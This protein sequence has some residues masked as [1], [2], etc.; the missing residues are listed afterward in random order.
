LTTDIIQDLTSILEEMSPRCQE[1]IERAIQEIEER[2]AEIAKLKTDLTKNNVVIEEQDQRFVSFFK[3]CVEALNDAT[4]ALEVVCPGRESR[5][6]ITETKE[7]VETAA[8]EG[9]PF[10]V[11]GRI[12]IAIGMMKETPP[13]SAVEPVEEKFTYS[14]KTRV[15]NRAIAIADF[16]KRT[17]KNSIKS[18]EAKIVLE[19]IE[20]QELD[21]TIIKRAMDKASKLLRAPKDI[22]GGVARIVLPAPLTVPTTSP[23]SSEEPGGVSLS[24]RRGTRLPWG[25]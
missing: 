22:F 12:R 11:V 13:I 19:D 9:R 25:G 18:T 14:T 15:E 21:R 1:V 3:F 17:G 23:S 20:G 4:E 5:V 7:K 6:F 2:D 10:A 24:R 8:P 16:M